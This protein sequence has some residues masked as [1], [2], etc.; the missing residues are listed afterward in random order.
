MYCTP[1][2][3]PRLGR[4]TFPEP[5]PSVTSVSVGR[6][7]PRRLWVPR[8]LIRA[9]ASY[10]SIPVPFLFVVIL[11]GSPISTARAIIRRATGMMVPGMG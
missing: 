4:S 10:S 5:V 9:L 1:A 3:N 8:L 2:N 11:V 6:P 7:G